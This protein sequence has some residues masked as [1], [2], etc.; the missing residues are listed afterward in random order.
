MLYFSFYIYSFI[1][2]FIFIFSAFI[3]SERSGHSSILIDRKLY[4]SGGNKIITSSTNYSDSSAVSLLKIE[5]INEFFYLDVSEQFTLTD[6]VSIP[7]IDL[8]YTGGPQKYLATAC[9]GGKNND[10]V[11]IFGGRTDSR[12]SFVNQFDTSKHKWTDITSVGSVPADRYYISCA[13]INNGLIT[14]FSGFSYDTN[15]TNDLWIFNTLAST[16]SLSNATYAPPSRRGYCTITLPDKNIIYIGGYS[17]NLSVYM[18]M[19]NL[20]L[21]NTKSDI[22]TN[23]VTPD[24]R[25]II[26][27]GSNVL[28]VSTTVVFGNL[29]ILN[30]T[31]FRW[32]IGNI[33]NPIVDLGHTATLVDN[34]MFIAFGE[35]SFKN[36]SSRIFMLDVSQKDSYRWVTEFTPNITTTAVSIPST[37]IQ[38]SSIISNSSLIIGGIIGDF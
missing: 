31:V 10:M 2:N 28:N 34:Y 11:F 26:F 38:S 5:I 33:L 13:N 1:L 21:Y 15:I 22:W 35:F 6:N 7:W 8:T 14:I 23:M 24:G 3:P 37:T 27:G 9:I 18:P 36:Y 17:S 19:N 20:P 29:W 32:S 16:W 12:Q 4:F 30:T 25:V